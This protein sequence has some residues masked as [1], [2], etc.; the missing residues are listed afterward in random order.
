MIGPC[1][2]LLA[3]AQT[4]SD[5]LELGAPDPSIATNGRYHNRQMSNIYNCNYSALKRDGQ[6]N[7]VNEV[8]DERINHWYWCTYIVL[9]SFNLVGLKGIDGE[10]LDLTQADV[11]DLHIYMDSTAGFQFVDY[12]TDKKNALAKVRPGYAFFV[13][14]CFKSYCAGGAHTGIIKSIDIDTRGN[15]SI[16]TL[17]S[18]STVKSHTW[19]IAEWEVIGPDYAGRPLVGF[20]GPI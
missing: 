13:E 2:P 14:A 15:G 17:E 8:V 4:V 5:H 9:D 7:I 16:I 11:R 12:R 20:G 18:N 1:G 10:I 3:W 19:A 6:A